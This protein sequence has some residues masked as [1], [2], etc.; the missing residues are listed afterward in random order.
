M[1][2]MGSIAHHSNHGVEAAGSRFEKLVKLRSNF[3]EVCYHVSMDFFTICTAQPSPAIC[4][5]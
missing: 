4:K 3:N 5:L 2:G 1:I